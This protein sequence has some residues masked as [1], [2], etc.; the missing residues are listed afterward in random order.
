MKFVNNRLFLVM[1]SFLLMNG[2]ILN[3]SNNST[4]PE[5]NAPEIPPQSTFLMDFSA[6]PDNASPLPRLNIPFG[7]TQSHE[8]WGWSVFNVLVWNTA[9]TVT[10]AIPVAAFVHSFNDEPE[11]RDGSWVWAYTFSV[12]G[13]QHSAELR[14]TTVSEGVNWEMF[15]SKQGV[16]QNFLWFNGFSNLPLTEGTWTLNK[17]PNEPVP[18]MGIE[19]HRNAQQNTADIKYTNIVQGGAENGGYIFYGST[20]GGPYDRFYDIFNKG[21]DNHTDIEWDHTS[22][23]GRVM[24]QHHFQDSEWHCWNNLL[25]DITCP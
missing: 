1:L 18:F 2:I 24:D 21:L 10:L 6:F 15:I 5:Q 23:E 11:F 25:E 16:Y 22:K 7:N 8:N 9:L 13:I 14:A 19:W 17:N 12:G 4:E 20:A 3:C